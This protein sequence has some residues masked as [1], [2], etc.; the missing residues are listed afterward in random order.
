MT[1]TALHDGLSHYSTVPLETVTQTASLLTRYDRKYLLTSNELP[2]LL[3]DLLPHYQL[4]DINAQQVFSYHSVYFDTPTADAY[5]LALTRRRRRFKV[6]TRTYLDSG[7]TFLEVKTR[8]ER[9]ST[10]K[11]RREHHSR[12]NLGADGFRYVRSTLDARTVN[13]KHLTLAPVLTT[14]YRRFTLTDLNTR[15]TIDTDLCW[16]LPDGRTYRAPDLVIVETKAGA[17]PSPADR[18]LWRRHRRPTRIS[19]FATGLAAFDPALPAQPWNRTLK[20]AFATAPR[21]ATTTSK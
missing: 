5:R 9:G 10:V 1:T 4:V 6:R 15:T 3:Q 7:Q 2:I 17:S 12:H 16:Q 11:D 14:T 19:K 13:T 20:T 21:F 18:A 8:G